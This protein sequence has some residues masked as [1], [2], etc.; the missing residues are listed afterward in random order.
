VNHAGGGDP[1]FYRRFIE[2][3]RQLLRVERETAVQ[4]RNQGRIGDELLREI[5]RELDLAEV[6]LAA[7][8]Q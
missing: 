6:R 7:G 3:S 2:V 4:M 1:N 5:E 8:K